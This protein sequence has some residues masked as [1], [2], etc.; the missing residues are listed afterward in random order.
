MNAI[1]GYLGLEPGAG[2]PWHMGA[3]ALNLG[4][5]ALAQVVRTRGYRRVHVPRFT[6]DVLMAPLLLCGVEVVFYDLDDAL[7]PL[8]MPG[9]D[10]GEGFLYTNYFGLKDHTVGELAG[11][12]RNLIV[13]NAQSFYAKPNPGVDTFYSCRKFFGVPD[14]AYLYCDARSR[15]EPERDVSYGRFAHLLRSVDEGPEAGY[16]DFKAN[17]DALGQV[18]LRTMSHLT[19]R[20]M[21]GIGHTR[22]MEKRRGNR[23]H[24]HGALRERNQ[25]PLDPMAA[26]VPFSYPFLSGDDALRERLTAHRIYTPRYWADTIA[27]LEPGTVEHRCAD[28][29]VHLPIDQ[30][31]GTREMDRILEVVLA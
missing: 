20:L 12:V 8:S 18:P 6:C 26:N 27:P 5:N 31:Y 11:G 9:P 13:D 3:L 23:D 22:V 14:G 1:G 21:H 28:G 19:E 17:E 4:R 15:D 24:L 29:I 7:A 16:A 10:D 2:Q 25:L 30:R